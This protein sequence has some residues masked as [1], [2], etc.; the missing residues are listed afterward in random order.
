MIGRSRAT[1][2]ART[3]MVLGATAGS[4]GMAGLRKNRVVR[5]HGR[6]RGGRYIGLGARSGGGPLGVFH[7]K[8]GPIVASEYP[9]PT[10]TAGADCEGSRDRH[11][12]SD[13]YVV[14]RT[15]HLVRR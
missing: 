6:L 14:H 10:E 3:G 5:R 15:R 7:V 12:E 8:A 13:P 11:R 4:F 1:G 9:H 2:F